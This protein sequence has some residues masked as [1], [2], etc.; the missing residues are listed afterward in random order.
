MLRSSILALAL[1][2]SVA[3]TGPLLAGYPDDFPWPPYPEEDFPE[4]PYPPFWEEADGRSCWSVC[5]DR[6][7]T[8]VVTHWPNGNYLCYIHGYHRW[9]GANPRYGQASC[10]VRHGTQTIRERRYY[11]CL[12]RR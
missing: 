6:D 9:R 12:C 2:V 10:I 4:R 3:G 7:A 1:L 8:P 5:D 11:S